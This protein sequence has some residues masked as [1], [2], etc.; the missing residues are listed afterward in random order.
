MLF[1]C[2]GV[3]VVRHGGSFIAPKGPI[4]IGLSFQK[5][6]EIWLS[7]GAPDR[8]HVHHVL[9]PDNLLP[10]RSAPNRVLAPL[11]RHMSLPHQAAIG[12]QI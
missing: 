5:Y 9:D 6:V 2:L 1:V 3:E 11:D 7:T 8:V 10:S 4:T 12:A